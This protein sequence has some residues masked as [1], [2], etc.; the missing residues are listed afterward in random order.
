[1]IGFG[2]IVDVFSTPSTDRQVA[3]NQIDGLEAVGQTPLWE[4]LVASA[5]IAAE[6]TSENGQTYVVLLADGDNSTEG[7]TQADAVREL[8]ESGAAL[9][10]IAVRS[11]RE[12]RR[13][14]ERG[15]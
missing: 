1:M 5:Q 10:A 6:T 11:A 4:A 7:V 9:Y 14:V 3:L 13:S 8:D 15:R 2:E 12:Q